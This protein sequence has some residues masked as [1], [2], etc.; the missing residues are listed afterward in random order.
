MTVLALAIMLGSAAL[1]SA[2]RLNSQAAIGFHAG[3][4]TGIGYAMRWMGPIHGAQVT[5]GA[6]TLGKKQPSFVEFDDWD[7]EYAGEDTINIVYNGRRAAIN[8]GL[9]YLYNLDEFGA[10]RVYIMAGGTYQ[11][12]QQKKF[13]QD[14]VLQPYD[15]THY[16]NFYTPQPGTEENWLKKEHRWTFGAGPGFEWAL[17]KQFRI[18]IELPITYNWEHDI[19]MWIPQGGIYYYF[20]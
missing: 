1:L 14:F 5:F 9:N 16:Y 17:S 8:I 18:A 13:S 15:G 4:S 7:N 10:G 6:Y 19:V 12:F 20:K 3:T 11:Y 2:E